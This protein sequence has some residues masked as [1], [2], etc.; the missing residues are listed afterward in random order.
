MKPN[1]DAND[2]LST[3]NALTGSL[4]NTT[5][6]ASSSSTAAPAS[7][8]TNVDGT[9]LGTTISSQGG[10][11][12]YSNYQHESNTYGGSSSSTSNIYDPDRFNTEDVSKSDYYQSLPSHTDADGNT[13]MKLNLT[14]VKDPKKG[15]S[16]IVSEVSARKLSKRDRRLLDDAIRLTVDQWQG[17]RVTGEGSEVWISCDIF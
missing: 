6:G 8:A 5:L 15:G 17:G 14:I 13:T 2:K 9:L 4:N 1:K 12:N 7:S 11:Q 10:F 3:S 16:K